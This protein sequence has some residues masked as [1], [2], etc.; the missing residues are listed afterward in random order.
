[1]SN[2]LHI[3]QHSGL[4]DHIICNAI[5]R[6][7]AERYD[8]IILNI[9]QST[10]GNVKYMYRDLDNIEF[11]DLY[12]VDV[13]SYVKDNPDNKYLVLGC[14]PEYFSNLHKR[15][16]KSFDYGFYVMADIP[17]EDRWDKFY[18]QRDIDKERY[19]YYHRLDL[20]DG[21]EYVF[22][23]EDP[24]RKRLLDYKLIPEGIKHIKADDFK[25]VSVFDFLYTIKK[26]KE[27]HV[28]DSCF[29]ALIDNMRL[30]HNK[31]FLH[32]YRGNWISTPTAIKLNWNIHGK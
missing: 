28:M 11:I 12:F 15:I 2:V 21:E 1:M 8:K 14:I 13:P 23:H 29:L 6:T 17:Y 30:V 4:G 20:E 3:L 7:Y 26:A 24:S 25:D 18:F 32:N 19:V 27:V 9:T 10:I 16:Y 22:I 31:L 5:I